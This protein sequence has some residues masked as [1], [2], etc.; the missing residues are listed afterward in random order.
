M[1]SK[2]PHR[3]E[4]DHN[5]TAN[6]SSDPSTSESSTEVEGLPLRS[7]IAP[8]LRNAATAAPKLMNKFGEIL[9]DSFCCCIFQR[10][11]D[12]PFTFRENDPRY[13]ALCRLVH[14]KHLTIG[15]VYAKTV[16]FFLIVVIAF[17]LQSESLIKFAFLLAFGLAVTSYALLFAGIKFKRFHLLLPFFF[18]SFI[19]I[20]IAVVHFFVDFLDSANTKDTTESNQ[21]AGF[22]F[23]IFAIAFEIYSLLVVW[24]LFN[25]ICDRVMFD[26]LEQKGVKMEE[27]LLGK[28]NSQ[29]PSVSISW[30]SRIEYQ[31][32]IIATSS[33]T[34]NV[35]Q[36]ETIWN[37]KKK[38]SAA[39][40]M[41]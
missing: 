38:F 14:V 7:T 41:V 35:T 37:S 36:P 4:R 5:S 29:K 26:E 20:M 1:G 33:N 2:S 32:S 31:R 16:I 25:Y 13:L 6:N 3:S 34:L 17:L 21:L 40:S 15:L 10:K 24:R 11:E 28:D 8:Q 22:L 19:F 30:A 27:P 39:Y 9:L 12:D 23:Q 18:V